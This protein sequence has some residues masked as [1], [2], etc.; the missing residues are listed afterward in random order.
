MENNKRIIRIFC[1]A[2]TR[3]R[4]VG[5]LHTYS[6]TDLIEKW[7]LEH[8]PPNGQPRTPSQLL[9]SKTAIEKSRMS[10]SKE[11]EVV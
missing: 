11:V 7:G 2:A 3:A 8:C 6:V 1:I 5:H 9:K 4:I 10:A